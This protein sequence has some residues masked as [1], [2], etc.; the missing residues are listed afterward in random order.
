[1]EGGDTRRIGAHD[2]DGDMSP[3]KSSRTTSRGTATGGRTTEEARGSPG[4]KE[5][6][7]AR[8]EILVPTD[9]EEE[10]ATNPPSRHGRRTV[11][12]ATA[13][14]SSTAQHSTSAAPDRDPLSNNNR[15]HQ[16]QHHGISS[17]AC[18]DREVK[19]VRDT[20]SA[21]ATTRTARDTGKDS[22][23]FDGRPTKERTNDHHAP[24]QAQRTSR[25]YAA[26]F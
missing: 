11:R 20:V 26:D 21:A 23:D 14:R 13:E 25:R 7:G 3:A 19:S 6:E 15:T 18:I 5:E 2:D 10:D 9:E 4:R 12:P 22:D 8:G 24:R 17:N 1:M 16:R